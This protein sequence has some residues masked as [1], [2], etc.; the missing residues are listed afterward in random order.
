[1]S[2]C[3]CFFGQT[4]VSNIKNQVLCPRLQNVFPLK[5]F[6][7]CVVAKCDVM[8]V[9]CYISYPKF[10]ACVASMPT[11]KSWL[12][13]LYFSERSKKS[14]LSLIQIR[15]FN[16][17]FYILSNIKSFTLPAVV[18]NLSHLHHL[19]HA[20]ALHYHTVMLQLESYYSWPERN[21]ILW[22]QSS[23]NRFV[24]VKFNLPTIFFF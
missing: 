1:M 3:C 23:W 7:V 2:L 11:S 15:A 14:N 5:K 12:T 10:P 4:T 21:F 16:A 9:S 6:P 18:G 19:P 13:N 17:I 8:L 22:L 20:S 24:K